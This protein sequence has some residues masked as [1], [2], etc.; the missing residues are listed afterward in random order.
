MAHDIPNKLFSAA[1]ALFRRTGSG[2]GHNREHTKH[3]SLLESLMPSKV[4]RSFAVLYQLIIP[5]IIREDLTTFL[6]VLCRLLIQIKQDQHHHRA[7]EAHQEEPSFHQANQAPGIQATQTAL[8]AW[9]Q[10]AAAAHQLLLPKG[11]IIRVEL[12]SGPH[13]Y[14]KPEGLRMMMLSG[15]SS[16]SLLALTGENEE[17]AGWARIWT[18]ED[19][20]VVLG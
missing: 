4:V 11:H 13:L 3:K 14:Q 19:E 8:A 10:V 7:M 2:S 1:E 6:H 9:S 15:T 12:R 17:L 20:D 5:T 16:C 18:L